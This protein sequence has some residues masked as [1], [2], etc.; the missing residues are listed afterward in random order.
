MTREFEAVVADTIRVEPSSAIVTHK[1]RW[2]SILIDVNFCI[3]HVGERM[4][5]TQ[6]PLSAKLQVAGWDLTRGGLSKI[7]ARL[8][9]V[10]DA[11]LLVLA[12]VLQ[13]GV[14]DL[15]P[16]KPGDLAH[17]LRQSRG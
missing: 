2:R 1:H 17:L 13:C 8:R 11:E 6:Q 12:K 16:G 3:F 5:L 9:R 10:N 7:E 4:L 14:S 15:Y